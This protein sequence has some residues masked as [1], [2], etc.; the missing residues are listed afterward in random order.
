MLKSY[1][2]TLV[3]CY[4]SLHRKPISELRSVTRHMGSAPLPLETGECAPP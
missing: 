3:K 4:S 2:K 1:S